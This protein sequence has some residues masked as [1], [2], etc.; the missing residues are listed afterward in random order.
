MKF[1]LVIT[2]FFFFLILKIGVFAQDVTQVN[3]LNRNEAISLCNDAINNIKVEKWSEAFNLLNE[4]ITIDST[5]RNSY[6][7]LYTVSMTDSL[8][9]DS[10]I[11]ILQK[12]KKVFQQDDEICYYLGELFKEKGEQKRAMVEFSMAIAFSKINGEDFRLVPNYYFNRA[13]ICLAKNMISTA[14]LDYTYA[15]NL[16]PNYGSAFANRGICFF[17][18]GEIDAACMD[19]K[20]AK[21]NGV[22]QVEEYLERNCNDKDSK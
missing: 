7:Q 11:S 6:L 5:H 4:A 9:R 2:F 19:W 12:S 17:K 13:N 10:T 21:D 20:A 15:L 22:I 1:K 3:L 8:Y 16:K 18:M 14:V